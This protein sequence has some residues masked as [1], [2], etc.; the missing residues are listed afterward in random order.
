METP[1]NYRMNKLSHQNRYRYIFPICLRN[2]IH[3]HVPSSEM[4]GTGSLITL[5]NLDVY[6]YS[7]SLRILN[8]AHAHVF[9]SWNITQLFRN[10]LFISPA[11]RCSMDH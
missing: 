9:Y 10:E 5:D 11:L 3:S 1:Q 8:T 6:M 4:E 2:V 7:G